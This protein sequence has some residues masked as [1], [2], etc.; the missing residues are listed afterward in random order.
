MWKEIWERLLIEHRG[1]TLGALAGAFMGLIYLLFGLW[2]MLIFALIVYTGY[3]IGK[4]IDR[5]EPV[6]PAE[7]T[8]RW[9]MDK[10]RLFR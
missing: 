8:W 3:Y 7:E 4:K 6:L 9:L 10:W 5:N 1:K 2:D